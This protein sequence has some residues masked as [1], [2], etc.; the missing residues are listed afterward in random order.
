MKKIFF[1]ISSTL[2]IAAFAFLFMFFGMNSANAAPS[3]TA[4]A[5]ACS[6]SCVVPFCTTN[7]QC[8]ASYGAGSTCLV[9]AGG[10]GNSCTL[11]GNGGSGTPPVV[12]DTPP[13]SDSTNYPDGCNATTTYSVTTGLLCS[14]GSNSS[15]LGVIPITDPFNGG[16]PSLQVN[17]SVDFQFAVTNPSGTDN[18][19]WTWGGSTPHGLHFGEIF[20]GVSTDPLQHF[21]RLSGTPDTTGPYNFFIQVMDNISGFVGS[22]NYS[23]TVLDSSA[24]DNLTYSQRASQLATQYGGTLITL[25]FGAGLEGYA[26]NFGG[27]VINSSI[28]DAA[29]KN[30]STGFYNSAAPTIADWQNAAGAISGFSQGYNG[31]PITWTFNTES[32]GLSKTGGLDRNSQP[33]YTGVDSRGGKYAVDVHPH[34][35]PLGNT[36]GTTTYTGTLETHDPSY[37]KDYWVDPTGPYDFG[38]DGFGGTTQLKI[39]QLSSISP[40]SANSGTDATV[41]GRNIYGGPNFYTLQFLNSSGSPVSVPDYR[42][43]GATC[44]GYQAGTGGGSPNPTGPYSSSPTLVTN[45]YN[46]S[47]GFSVSS[48]GAF[49][50]TIPTLATGSYSVRL[51]TGTG[52]SNTIPFTITGGNPTYGITHPTI[53]FKTNNGHTESD[54]VDTY[55]T[56]TTDAKNGGTPWSVLN[57]NT[58][59]FSLRNSQP[60][61]DVNMYIDNPTA[62]GLSS[63]VRNGSSASSLYIVKLGTTDANGNFD[64]TSR[65]IN[66][67]PSSLFFE[68]TAGFERQQ[69][70]AIFLNIA[71]GGPTGGTFPAGCTSSSGFSTT[72]GLPCS[73]SGS[74]GSGGGSL[75][76]NT[77]TLTLTCTPS[78]TGGTSTCTATVP[79]VDAA[80]EARAQQQAATAARTQIS[81]SVQNILKGIQTSTSSLIQQVSPSANTS[82]VSG[83]T[84]P[85]DTPPAIPPA[86]PAATDCPTPSS[87]SSISSAEYN[88]QNGL[89]TI[90]G[91]HLGLI[92]CG[93]IALIT[94][95]AGQEL[96]TTASSVIPTQ[97]TALLGTGVGPGIY[98]VRIML[99]ANPS[100]YTNTTKFTVK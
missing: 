77:T 99:S 91:T 58:V 34:Y 54:T 92:T 93:N 37:D 32:G 90:H 64:Y 84:P 52:F 9:F 100:N 7:A 39:P 60:L 2:S 16:S 68:I 70:N 72:T 21:S 71:G 55:N 74:L 35:P 56:P 87:E 1:S 29:D 4:P 18:Y 94:T 78:S 42:C 83:N 61:A 17:Q 49:S 19:T 75:N 6:N 73:G 57:G 80:A 66:A 3:C 20:G 50:F 51:N 63:S 30:H 12:T 33:W 59:G 8:V 43:A 81:N 14:G 48:T 65:P 79:G 5:I 24:G 82:V 76:T 10:C 47:I 67:S 44:G 28:I 95:P 85:T 23:G 38:A 15:S 41:T 98:S 13:A 25:P 22:K 31:L 45:S 27:T 36:F 53:V 89:V 62:L 26:I 88:P 40:T 96:S 11:T 46:N 69:G 97:L 86:T